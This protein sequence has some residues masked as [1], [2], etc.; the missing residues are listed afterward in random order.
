MINN[1][2]TSPLR[3]TPVSSSRSLSMNW[4]E[5]GVGIARIIFGLVWV[6]AALLQWFPQFQTTFVAQVTAAKGG[7]PGF[8][9][10]WISFWANLVSVNPLLFARIL[11][12]MEAAIALFL[13][14]GLFSNL[15]SLV[16]IVLSLGIWSVP[17]GF[18]G[19]YVPGFSTDVGTAFP[20]AILFL[21]LLCL[22]AG[23]YYGVDQWLTPRLGR[24]GFLASGSLRRRRK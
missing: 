24:W 5:R 9:Q 16:G 4:R 3:R 15:T 18:G 22:S 23:R 2:T 12:T 11:A 14:L 19:P 10:G 20:Y 21:V 6:V 7:Q 1:P 8:I 17:E 13:I